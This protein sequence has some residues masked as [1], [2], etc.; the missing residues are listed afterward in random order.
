[1]SLHSLPSD[2]GHRDAYRRQLEQANADLSCAKDSPPPTNRNRQSPLLGAGRAHMDMAPPRDEQPEHKH[3]VVDRA[4]NDDRVIPSGGVADAVQPPV[5]ARTLTREVLTRYE[6]LSHV[7][8][9]DL[10]D[11][12]RLCETMDRARA[13][14]AALCERVRRRVRVRADADA[15]GVPLALLGEPR[16]GGANEA[17]CAHDCVVSVRS[18]CVRMENQCSGWK[19]VGGGGAVE[20]RRFVTLRFY[21]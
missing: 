12:Y 5:W 1:M 21:F 4:A 15:G 13:D 7:N 11:Y 8:K 18:L 14:F 2:I 17:R 6:S 10:H 19:G 20:V 16:T 3:N 9:R